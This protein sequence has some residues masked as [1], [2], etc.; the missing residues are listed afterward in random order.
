MTARKPSG[1]WAPL[2]PPKNQAWEEASAGRDLTNSRPYRPGESF[3]L[4][5]VIA[6]PSFGLGI[7]MG[8]KEGRKMI[9]VFRDTTRILVQGAK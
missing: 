2:P 4:G 6:H 9:V 8:F 1:T 3:A 5:D 7:V